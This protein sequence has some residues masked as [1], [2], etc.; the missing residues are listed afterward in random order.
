MGYVSCDM[1][2]TGARDVIVRKHLLVKCPA[3]IIE[4]SFEKTGSTTSLYFFFRAHTPKITKVKLNAAKTSEDN[5]NGNNGIR[6]ST[7]LIQ[8]PSQKMVSGKPPDFKVEVDITDMLYEGLDYWRIELFNEVGFDSFSFFLNAT[9]TPQLDKSPLSTIIISVSCG[10]VSIVVIIVVIIKRRRRTT[11][12][13]YQNSVLLATHQLGRPLQHQPL[14]NQCG[15]VAMQELEEAQSRRSNGSHSSS[16]NTYEEVDDC[17]ADAAEDPSQNTPRNKPESSIED[18]YLHPVSSTGDLNA[19]PKPTS[20]N[21]NA[22]SPPTESSLKLASAGLAV[23][24]KSKSMPTLITGV[25]E[26]VMQVNGEDGVDEA[27][28]KLVG[29]CEC[30]EDISEQLYENTAL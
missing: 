28:S 25:D 30:G 16:N 7:L 15:R 9:S 27:S 26:S 24:V 4:F 10:A 1:Q 29:S 20:V 18:S 3:K 12:P 5:A 11:P 6:P 8:S 13:L 19:S 22:C 17:S 14:A 21:E 23:N 2:E